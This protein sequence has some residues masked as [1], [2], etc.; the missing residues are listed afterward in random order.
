MSRF[1]PIAQEQERSATATNSGQ[2]AMLARVLEFWHEN[3]GTCQLCEECQCYI[4]CPPKP[5]P[6]RVVYADVV[7]EA[8]E[9]QKHNSLRSDVQIIVDMML[10]KYPEVESLIL[11]DLRIVLHCNIPDPPEET[12]LWEDTGCG[13]CEHKLLG[14]GCAIGDCT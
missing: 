8:I 5:A 7:L 14:G 1:T 3:A 13:E 6:R 10:M 4:G 11:S 12:H 9:W 2:E